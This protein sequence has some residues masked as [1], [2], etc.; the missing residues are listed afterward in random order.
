MNNFV[1]CGGIHTDDNGTISSPRHPT[2]YPHN[3]SCTWLI[4]APETHIIRLTFTAFRTESSGSCSFDYVLVEDTD[5]VQ[6]GKYATFI[7]TK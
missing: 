3:I 4:R 2:S 5:G 7:S 6:V 1:G